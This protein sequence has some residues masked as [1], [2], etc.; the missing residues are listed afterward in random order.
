MATSLAQQLQGI[1]QTASNINFQKRKRVASLIFDASEA[2]DQDLDQV[3]AIAS[4]GYEELITHNAKLS[5][6]SRTIFAEES[7]TVDRYTQTK[8]E[9]KSLDKNISAFIRAVAPFFL[10]RSTH[11]C[12]EWLIRRFDIHVHLAQELILAF[13]PFHTTSIFVKLLATIELPPAWTFLG[14]AKKAAE[15]PSVFL[16]VKSFVKIRPTLAIYL[17]YVQK[18]VQKEQG[19][20]AMISQFADISVRTISIMRDDSVSEDTILSGFL[21]YVGEALSMK[22]HAEYQVANY[23]VLTVLS[24]SRSISETAN[25]AL[26]QALSSGLSKESQKSGL[27]C[28][29]QLCQTQEG[30]AALSREVFLSLKQLSNVSDLLINMAEKYR[31]DKLL[32]AYCLSLVEEATPEAL[33]VIQKLTDSGRVSV[34]T[35]LTSISHKVL[36]SADYPEFRVASTSFFERLQDQPKFTQTLKVFYDS[37]DS[38]LDD[39]ELALQITLDLPMDTDIKPKVRRQSSANPPV[40]L[41]DDIAELPNLSSGQNYLSTPDVR[42]I[43]NVLQ[44]ATSVARFDDVLASP[45]INSN[46]DIRLSFLVRAALSSNDVR[47][48]VCALEKITDICRQPDAPDYQALIPAVIS[49]LSSK[50]SEVRLRSIDLAQVLHDNSTHKS[51]TI[52]GIDNLYG[53]DHSAGLKWL[54]STDVQLLLE[55]VILA[56]RGECA[57]DHKIIYASVGKALTTHGHKGKDL[58]HRVALSHFLASHINCSPVMKISLK[59]LLC[60]DKIDSPTAAKTKAVLPALEAWIS[61]LAVHQSQARLELIDPVVVQKLLVQ[62]VAPTEHGPGTA[63][64]M[65]VVEDQ[66]DDFGPAV[67]QWLA[68]IFASLKKDTKIAFIRCLIEAIINGPSQ[69]SR[70][71]LSSIENI[72]V[73]SEIYAQMMSEIDL[74]L[75][76][77]RLSTPMK[78]VKTSVPAASPDHGLRRFTQLLEVLERDENKHSELLPILFVKLGDLVLIENESTVSVSYTEQLLL[79]CMYPMVD[80]GRF[81]PSTT[82]IDILINC[83]RGSSSPQVH[84]RALLLVAALAESAPEQVLHGLMP[85]FTFMGANILR[86][87]DGFSAHVIESTIQRVIPPLLRSLGEEAQNRILGSA[88]ILRSFVDAFPHIPK[89]RRNKLFSVLVQTLGEDVF[90]APLLAIFAEKR[91]SLSSKTKSGESQQS[92]M[93]FILSLL[94]Q[95]SVASQLS[96]LHGLIELARE[97][98][99]SC[100]SIGD[101]KTLLNYMNSTDSSLAKLKTSIVSIIGGHFASKKVRAE[102][103]IYANDSEWPDR[104]KFISIVESLLKAC[105]DFGD[106]TDALDQALDALDRAITLLP[107]TLFQVVVHDLLENRKDEYLR[108]KA[109]DIITSRASSSETADEQSRSSFHALVEQIASLVQSDTSATLLCSS[110]QCISTIG[111]KFGKSQPSSFAFVVEKVIGDCGLRNN[112]LIVRVSSIECLTTLVVVLGPRIIPNL[113]KFMPVVLQGFSK[114]SRDE[115][116]DLVP[117]ATVSLLESLVKTIPSFLTPHTQVMMEKSVDFSFATEELTSDKRALLS[118][119]ALNMP[120]RNVL[121]ALAATWD[122]C[123][124]SGKKSLMALVS[125]I[126]E[127][128]ENSER[129]VVTG[130]AKEILTLFLQA[131]DLRRKANAWDAK[132]IEQV[133]KRIIAAFLKLVLK[134]N[135]STFRPLFVKLRDW[136]LAELVDKDATGLQCRRITFFNFFSQ[137]CGTFKSIVLNYFNYVNEDILELLSVAGDTTIV[138]RRLWA[139]I[140]NS[141]THGFSSDNEDFWRSADKFDRFA[142]AL[143]DQL[144]YAETYPVLTTLIPAIV[145]LTAA[146]PSDEHF[147]LINTQV[148]QGFRAEK[149]SVRSAAVTTADKLSARLGDEWLAMLPQTVPFIAEALEDED[150]RVEKQTHALALTIEK[151]LGESLDTYLR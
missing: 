60:F 144:E 128:I 12:L 56:N 125:V 50:A 115:D 69:I 38:K 66:D 99:E 77:T 113:E 137:F 106:S 150:E 130:A 97:I 134:L 94:R 28:L 54:S 138:P 95:F 139:G 34:V 78:K 148:L 129:K 67:I 141:L 1:R 103:Q 26:M 29:A 36:A 92:Y 3:F 116:A 52:W 149:P 46:S 63:L 24:A 51:K 126:E 145:E 86:Q 122:K 109:L 32:T 123:Y 101:E 102:F 119:I 14:A 120:T 8:E 44:A 83:I 88:G 10:L 57:L 91:A 25:A 48:Q 5:T 33:Q 9:N 147:K 2:A 98:P 140:I 131:L 17:D 104:A 87:D 20:H 84:N 55:Q 75:S 80:S 96:A 47:T 40:S 64:L 53:P 136:A 146:T 7:R 58:S 39:L 13:M 4:N 118:T 49:L 45:V 21:P 82:R 71:A 41:D 59:L 16:F 43:I 62:Q 127:T 27:I 142:P 121:Q 100:E 117:L 18:I 93:E 23:M 15:T 6:F 42:R 132:G 135:D 143:T 19:F 105:E 37:F 124:K 81:D 112:E 70:Q 72:Q 151:F 74:S 65:K 133:E 89:H 68:T 111:R 73:S 114:Q 79:S 76:S 90:L 35:V 22:S 31:A 108:I 85:I 30:Y 61:D 107:V 110:W 11:K